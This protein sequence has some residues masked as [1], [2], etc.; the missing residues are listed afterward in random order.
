[1]EFYEV[2]NRRFSVRA[3]KSDPVPD[4]VLNRILEAGRRA[5]SAKNYQPWK[6]IVV[7]DAAVRQ[8]LVPACRNQAFIAQAPVV[9]CGCAIEELAWKKMGGYW[10]AAVV[11]VAIAL[12]HIILAATAEGLGTCWIGAFKE[13]EVRKVLGIPDGVKPVALT[14]LGYPAQEPKPQERKPLAEI[15][16]FDR[17]Q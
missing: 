8:A 10:S 17:Y 14:P 16:C 1:M 15:V 2:V 6:F 7:K 5:P 13:E 9:I 4:E 12:E 3:Y 11:D